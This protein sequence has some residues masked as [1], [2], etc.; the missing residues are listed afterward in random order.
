M[1][2]PFR[3]FTAFASDIKI[4]HS[5]F[6]LPFVGVALLLSDVS[7]ITPGQMALILVC[8]ISARSFAMGMNRFLDHDVDFEN[9]RTAGRAIPSGRLSR[10]NC[11]RISVAFAVSFIIAAFALSRLA[12]ILSIP[13]LL[14]LA[15]YSWM[16][17][18]TWLTHWYLGLCLGLA[19]VAAQIAL[20][21]R[22]TIQVLLIGLAVA[23]WTAGFDLLYA[24]QDREFDLSKKLNSVPA[25]FGH[26]ATLVASIF[27][28]CLMI[29]CL[30][31]A[32]FLSDVH[33]MFYA[34]IILVSLI[35]FFEHWMVRDAWVNGVSKNINAA[36]FN[37]NALVSVLFFAFV[38]IDKVGTFD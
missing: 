13:M 3:A 37:A 30:I 9:P 18:L 7:W 11:L 10:A 14:V 15:S 21:G 35:L 32:G 16:K 26:R 20:E 12:G 31:F 38:V 4:A 5:I 28:F 23:F 6:A 17:R 2:S 1:S 36:F 27:S 8:M 34:G 25:V 33:G 29:I 22:A 19:P 24:L